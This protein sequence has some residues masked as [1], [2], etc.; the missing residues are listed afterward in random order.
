MRELT[1][2]ELDQVT[3]GAAVVPQE[4]VLT[5]FSAG[6]LAAYHAYFGA[7]VTSREANGGLRDAVGVLTAAAA[8]SR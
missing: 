6:G 4:G 7:Q 5:S 1:E 8:Q 3:G 2:A